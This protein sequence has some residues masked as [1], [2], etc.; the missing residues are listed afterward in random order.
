MQP[1]EGLAPVTHTPPLPLPHRPVATDLSALYIHSDLPVITAAC[2]FPL[3]A[4]NY[5]SPSTGA[6]ATISLLL[7]CCTLFRV[8]HQNIRHVNLICGR[9]YHT[10]RDWYLLPSSAPE[11]ILKD[12]PPR[13]RQQLSSPGCGAGLAR[14]SA[15]ALIPALPATSRGNPHFA[16]SIS[17]SRLKPGPSMSVY[18]GQVRK[19]MMA[20]SFYT[21]EYALSE[22]K[23]SLC[24]EQI[25]RTLTTIR[26]ALHMVPRAAKRR[27]CHVVLTLFGVRVNLGTGDHFDI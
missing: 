3:L 4:H 11:S 2:I 7:H 27:P 20:R 25:V 9:Q 22:P 18:L 15:L 26:R 12:T 16:L 14:G 19:S 17:V 13:A 6:A 21:R 8:T 1:P 5:R 10:P 23:R 24:T